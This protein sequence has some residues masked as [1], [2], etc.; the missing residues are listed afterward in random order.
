MVKQK[1]QLIRASDLFREFEP[2]LLQES[3]WQETQ[4]FLMNHANDE[5][6]NSVTPADIYHFTTYEQKIAEFAYFMNVYGRDVLYS[7]GRT[8][9]EVNIDD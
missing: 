7:D 6:I 8:A 1:I 9:C 2:E 3:E 5:R 4:V